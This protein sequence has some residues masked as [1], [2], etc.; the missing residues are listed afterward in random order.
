MFLQFCLT[1]C[2]HLKSIVCYVNLIL[3]KC[4][5]GVHWIYL[6]QERGHKVN[7]CGH[8]FYKRQGIS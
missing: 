8:G 5:G 1:C 2:D 4:V 6:S 7:S 3:D